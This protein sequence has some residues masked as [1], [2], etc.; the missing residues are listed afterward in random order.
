[1]INATLID[2][3][4]WIEGSHSNSTDFT[5]AVVDLAI[6]HGFEIDQDV[7]ESD[8]AI[9]SARVADSDMYEALDQTYYDA[10]EYLNSILPEG[11]WFEVYEQS[12]YLT[13][14][15]QDNGDVF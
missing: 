9:F 6:Q 15:S 4:I 10:L 1:M 11:Y 14:E 5:V 3:G 12:L 7:W 2:T 13:H 8:R